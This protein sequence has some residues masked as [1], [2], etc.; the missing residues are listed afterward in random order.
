M[1]AD[2]NPYGYIVELNGP[3]QLVLRRIDQQLTVKVCHHNVEGTLPEGN[4][5]TGYF[6]LHDF[7]FNDLSMVDFPEGPL[8]N[9]HNDPFH[10]KELPYPTQN[11]PPLLVASLNLH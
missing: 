11:D 3:E 2:V 9:D 7:C 5:S 6:V 1:L 8:P 10:H 4:G